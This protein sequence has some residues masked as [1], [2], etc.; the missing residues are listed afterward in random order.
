MHGAKYD[1]CISREKKFVDE[2]ANR[3]DDWLRNVYVIEAETTH[4][5]NEKLSFHP[6]IYVGSVVGDSVYASKRS[7]WTL[8]CAFFRLEKN[9]VSR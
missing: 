1:N 3:L 6:R 4:F 8:K 5:F 2:A 7:N 9:K